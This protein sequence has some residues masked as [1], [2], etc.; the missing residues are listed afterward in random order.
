M[1]QCPVVALQYQLVEQTMRALKVVGFRTKPCDREEDEMADTNAN[2]EEYWR[3]LADAGEEEREEKMRTHYSSLA[4]MPEEQRRE[5]LK[6]MARVEYTLP[7]GKIRPFHTSRLRI[8]LSMEPDQ[9]RLVAASTEAIMNDMPGDIA[10]RRV[11]VVQTLAR[12]FNP[13]D[14]ARLRELV[15]RVFAEQTRFTLDQSATDRRE[16]LERAAEA[17]APKKPWWAFW[18]R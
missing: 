13:A 10:M 18:K 4:A 11:A 16:V 1:K 7:E 2:L 9:A 5:Q 6:T 17:P 8:W 14:Q 15:P 12:N 3:G